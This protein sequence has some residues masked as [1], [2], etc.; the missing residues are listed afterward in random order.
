MY[1][2][3]ESDKPSWFD[4]IFCRIVLKENKILLPID[5]K[6]LS[7]KKTKKLAD[8][9]KK[10]LTNAMCKKIILSKMVKTQKQYVN[11]LYSYPLEIVDGRWLFELLSG[12][13]LDFILEKKEMKKEETNISILANEL[14][15]IALFNIKKIVKEFKTVNIITNHLERFRKLESQIF[16]EEGIMITVGNNKRKGLAKSKVILNIDFPSELVNQY[17]IYDKAIIVNIR[18]NVKISKKRFNG[19]TIND[20]DIDFKNKKDLDFNF[21]DKFKNYEFYEALLNKKQPIIDNI[22][23]VEKDGV[24]I[25]KLIGVNNS[26]E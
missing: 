8:K 25:T 21:D 3:Q 5:E 26:F 10:F 15:E 9:T 6:I 17:Q 16:E 1:Y 2:I 7:D 12:K 18:E 14:T 22:R 13:I 19:I 24:I 23:K 20:Y 4:K 11:L